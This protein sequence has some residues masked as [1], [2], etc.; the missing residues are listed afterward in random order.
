M[1]IRLDDVWEM[2][3]RCA[4]GY[5]RRLTD[6]YYRVTYRDTCY[7]SLPKGPHG[8]KSGQGAIPAGEV[9]SMARFFELDP[10]CVALSFP[11]LVK[12]KPPS[13]PVGPYAEQ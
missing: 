13:D 11:G 7:A 6:H 2:L 8:K 10:D 4:H 3:D 12:R 9:R 5:E 1:Q